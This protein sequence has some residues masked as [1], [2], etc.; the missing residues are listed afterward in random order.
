MQDWWTDERVESVVTTRFVA[1]HLDAPLQGQLNHVVFDELSNDT[2]LDW[3]LS[4]ARR[5]FLVL[6]DCAC[7]NHIFY[8]IEQS[9]EDTS[10]PIAERHVPALRLPPRSGSDVNRLFFRNQFKYLIR[11]IREGE[12]IRYS[13]SA[14]IPIH[15]VDTK[16]PSGY[17]AAQDRVKLPQP[18]NKVFLRLREPMTGDQTEASVLSEITAIRSARHEHIASV[19]GSYSKGGSMYILTSP[20]AH[21]SLK[22]F[23]SDLPKLFKAMPKPERQLQLLF[24]PQCLANAVAWIHAN[25]FVHGAISPSRILVDDGFNVILGHF[26]D[27]RAAGPPSASKDLEYY[28]YA[29]PELH[30]RRLVVQR[31]G[32]SQPPTLDTLSEYSELH[33]TISSID[34]SIPDLPARTSSRSDFRSDFHPSSHN[35]T[36]PLSRSA[37]RHDSPLES[38]TSTSSKSPFRST[39]HSISSSSTLSSSSSNEPPTSSSRHL[40]PSIRPSDFRHQTLPTTGATVVQT[41]HSTST[42]LQSCDIFSL[43][44]VSLDILT[45]LLGTSLSSFAKH[46]ASAS[47]TPSSRGAAAVDSSFHA[48]LGQVVA[49]ARNLAKEAEKKTKKGNKVMGAVGPDLGALVQCLDRRAGGRLGAEVLSLSLEGNLREFA[50][51]REGHCTVKVRDGLGGY[52]YEESTRGKEGGEVDWLC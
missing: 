30:Q 39:T 26:K 45:V 28:Q 49:W 32:A 44:C 50:G 38:P 24:W 40:P 20:A 10:L 15:V 27:V 23:L 7:V 51:V 13:S 2:Y 46:R 25:G 22:G 43:A 14:N 1:S 47:R 17:A 21:Y 4:R 41:L 18:N 9:Y 33:D 8:L 35:G 19:F 52:G 48:N 42:D 12:H 37:S 3:I 31:S 16:V 36:H 6:V 5:L 11:T 34:R 29:A